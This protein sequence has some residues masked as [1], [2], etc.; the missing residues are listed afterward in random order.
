MSAIGGVISTER[1]V[2]PNELL[3][4][5]SRAMIL[6]GRD[7]RGAYLNR[8]FGV[9]YNGM[10]SEENTLPLQ[11]ITATQSEATC[12]VVLDGVLRRED[13]AAR[14]YRELGEGSDA[15][16]VLDTYLAFGSDFAGHLHGAFAL[17]ILDEKRGELLLAR[18][19]EGLRPLYY[20]AENDSLVFA[21]EIKGLF[22]SLQGGAR[23]DTG[24]LRAHVISPCG[25]YGA[26]DLYRDIHAI[27][28]GHCGIY[29][30]LGLNVFPYH[31]EAEPLSA[32]PITDGIVPEFFCPD[33][34]EMADLLHEALFAFDYPEFDPLMPAHLRLL[35]RKAKERK[36]FSVVIEDGTLC[37]N[38][39]YSHQRADRLG[40]LTGLSVRGVAP[41]G[42]PLRE[43]DLKKMDRVLGKLLSAIDCEPLCRLF[44]SDWRESIRMEKNTA[45]RIRMQGLLYQ[46]LLWKQHYPVLFL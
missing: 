11:P 16:F 31:R 37:M 45:K 38:I 21:S 44:G 12:T 6:R 14:L 1:G 18:D 28:A 2:L 26:E 19:P 22:Y 7:R 17:A 27:P 29:S 15:S 42:V 13:T 30:R 23:V 24:R 46:T 20:T 25:T 8:R 32:E 39:D 3:P 5:M 34:K 10:L 35:K 36:Q 9:L 43:K 40:M 33:E 4:E 41:R